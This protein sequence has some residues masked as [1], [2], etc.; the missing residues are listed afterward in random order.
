LILLGSRRGGDFGK[1]AGRGASARG[2]AVGSAIDELHD[3]IVGNK[4]ARVIVGTAVGVLATSI[5]AVGMLVAAYKI[6]KAIYKVSSKAY[7]TYDRTHDAGEAIRA[8][9]GEAVHVGADEARDQVIGKMVDVGWP[10]I[11]EAAGVTTDEM[12][13]KVLT[14]A[15]KSTLSE[16]LPE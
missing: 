1:F 14:S 5:P 6:S 8:A 15:A 12:E 9:A 4:P 7:A 2:R 10:E 11:K 3:A 13:D 16:V